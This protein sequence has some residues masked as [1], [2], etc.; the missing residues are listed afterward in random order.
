LER[1]V[2]RRDSDCNLQLVNSRCHSFMSFSAIVIIFRD[3]LA[4][5]FYV[6]IVSC[7]RSWISV[8][9]P[10]APSPTVTQTADFE[11]GSMVLRPQS[12]QPNRTDDSVRAGVPESNR[13]R[14]GPDVSDHR[15]EPISDFMIRVFAEPNRSEA[16]RTESGAWFGSEWFDSEW[17]DSVRWQHCMTQAWEFC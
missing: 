12:N 11:R 13:T 7:S 8:V 14:P 6:V 3:S 1:I 15:I 5:L 17:F 16:Y 4:S 10:R 2:C 9:A